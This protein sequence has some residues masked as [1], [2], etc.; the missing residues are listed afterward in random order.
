MSVLSAPMYR[1]DLFTLFHAETQKTY[2]VIQIPVSVSPLFC[3]AI[4]VS[5][6]AD[7]LG[8]TKGIQA[9]SLAQMPNVTTRRVQG[10]R[11]TR[12]PGKQRKCIRVRGGD[13]W[14]GAI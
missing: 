12:G 11:S 7:D 10:L 9:N 13:N 14:I 3:P 8:A 4:L 6:L 1:H 5:A 2:K